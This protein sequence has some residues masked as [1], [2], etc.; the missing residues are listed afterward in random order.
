MFEVKSI[1]EDT[2]RDKLLNFCF[3]FNAIIFS[4]WIFVY[5]YAG[6]FSLAFSILIFFL[7]EVKVLKHFFVISSFFLIL[8][9]LF[10][11]REFGPPN[12]AWILS[13]LSFL[14]IFYLN[15]RNIVKIF[16][17][18]IN[19]IIL[20]CILS[21][22]FRVMS[23]FL[24]LPFRFIDLDPQFFNLYWPFYVE[25]TNISS[26]DTDLIIGSFRFHGPFFE[27]GAIGYVLGICL[28]GQNSIKKT[29][30]IIFFGLLSFS[31]AFLALLFI[32]IFEKFLRERNLCLYSL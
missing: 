24:P 15:R 29:L 5:P 28:F 27:P 32:F 26:A 22:F 25:R 8:L 2:L 19:F 18:Y 23:L 31:M 13:L 10:L 7:L 16:E 11:P 1:K 4:G 3:L 14:T 12:T 17:I 21:L 30:L 9:Y 6:Y 20:L